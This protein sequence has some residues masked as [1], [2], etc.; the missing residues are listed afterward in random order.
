MVAAIRRTIKV[1]QNGRIEIRS[2]QLLTGAT[3]EVIILLES[4]QTSTPLLL[5]DDLQRIMGLD[6]A[7][8]QAWARQSR[9]QRI[10]SARDIGARAE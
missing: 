1:E 7:S 6:R 2:P 5:L 9:D 8:A 10:S 3:A 4:R